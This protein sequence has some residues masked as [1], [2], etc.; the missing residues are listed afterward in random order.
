MKKVNQIMLIVT[1]CT[2]VFAIVFLAFQT[3]RIFV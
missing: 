3:I 1:K 2:I